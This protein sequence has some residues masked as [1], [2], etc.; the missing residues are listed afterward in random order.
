MSRSIS[1]TQQ[2]IVAPGFKPGIFAL[3]N[4]RHP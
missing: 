4:R 1:R 2:A 3:S